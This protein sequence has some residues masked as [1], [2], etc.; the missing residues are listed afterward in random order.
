[1]IEA[2]VLATG[3]LLV[4]AGL[5]SAR[6]P[7]GASLAR[8]GM[9]ISPLR[10]FVLSPIHPQTWYANG[11][12]ILGF[13]VGITAFVTIVTLASTGLTILLAGVGVVFIAA[14]I[15]G[16]RLVA[17]VER[18][19]AFVGEAERPAPHPYR[20]L[21]GSILE[22]LRAEFLDEAR[23]R[24]VLYVAINFPLTVLEFIVVGLAWAAALAALTMPIW[25]EPPAFV[26]PAW[27]GSI[28][29]VALLF[30]AASLS[31]LVIRLHRQVVAGLLCTSESRELRRQVETL[32]QSR[33]AVL[34]VEASEL[35]RIERDLHDGAQQRLARLSMDLGLASERIDTDPATAKQLVREGQEQAR[36]ALAEI[37]QLVRGIAPS[38][39]LDRGLVAA[40]ESITG[41]GPVSTA[42]IN[43]LPPGER[44]PLTI[45]RAAYFV[46]SE[47]LANVAKHSDATRCEVRCRREGG[48]LVVEIWDDGKGGASAESGGGLEGLENRVVAVDGA[49]SVSSPPGG[50]TIV[51]AEFPIPADVGVSGW[52][53]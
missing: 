43:E 5:A 29:G 51:R 10:A 8:P 28:A 37:R 41:R 19:R 26:P 11:A 52:R 42:V 33:S 34:A 15:E 44:L 6:I 47:A 50:P 9:S 21:R 38:I 14:A 31:Q 1:V 20:P 18:W 48:T 49:F 46:V 45:E 24:D 27:L 53:V 2:V 25:F 22:L 12:I 17:R 30:V 32:R 23:W 7:G 40:I 4:L 39:L 36:E 35:A 16:S 3:L 13:F